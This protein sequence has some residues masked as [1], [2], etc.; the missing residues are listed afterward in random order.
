M[1]LGAYVA[2][3]PEIN[4]N[5][6]PQCVFALT[7]RVL[8]LGPY[9]ISEVLD[10]AYSLH[11]PVAIGDPNQPQPSLLIMRVPSGYHC[12]V[13]C[14]ASLYPTLRTLAIQRGVCIV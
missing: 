5:C 2:L 8:P 3:S 11:I 4:V 14:S 9:P 10:L 6:F 1:H 13:C 7:G 12:L